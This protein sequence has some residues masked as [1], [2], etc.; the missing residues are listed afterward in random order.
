M[1]ATLANIV[2]HAVFSMF[3]AISPCPTTLEIEAGYLRAKVMAATLP[4]HIHHS[5]HSMQPAVF[6]RLVALDVEEG[7]RHT[8]VMRAPLDGDIHH[9]MTINILA[10]CPPLAYLHFE[11]RP[12]RAAVMGALYAHDCRPCRI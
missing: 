3:A 6:T 9:A 11:G 5:V 8:R 7:C 10:A 1:Q 2:Y 12:L 4:Q